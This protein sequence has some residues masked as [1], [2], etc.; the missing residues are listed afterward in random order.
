MNLFDL[1]ERQASKWR[2]AE[3]RGQET[4]V[5]TC[6]L[7]LVSRQ[8]GTDGAAIGQ[9]IADRLGFDF[10]NQK[11]LHEI[12]EH[13]GLAEVLLSSLDERPKNIFLEAFAAN[14]HI[15]P[16]TSEYMREL[17]FQF[18]IIGHHSNA[19]VLGR[20]AQFALESPRTFRVRLIAPREH[21]A[22]RLAVQQGI[23]ENEARAEIDQVDA[24]RTQ[25]I[26]EQWSRDID[27]FHA[28]DLLVNV[29]YLSMETAADAVVTAYQ[30]R[31]N[32]SS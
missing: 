19:V 12:A 6:P 16:T 26:Y 23:E 30:G 31:F 11:L 29:E 9:R 13:G 3:A 28:Y 10:W 27:D 24:A 1:A 17:L 22:K 14:K 7:V 18:Q 20:G 15:C 4:K 21:R 2:R 25:F 32:L 8:H 5:A